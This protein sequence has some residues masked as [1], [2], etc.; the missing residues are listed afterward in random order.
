[1]HAHI[2][3]RI[4]SNSGSKREGQAGISLSRRLGCGRWF[5]TQT[6]LPN[7]AGRTASLLLSLRFKPS[8]I[9]IIW[10]APP[11]ALLLH[12]ATAHGLGGSRGEEAAEGWQK[13]GLRGSL[14]EGEEPARESR[15]LGWGRDATEKEP[16]V[17]TSPPATSKDTVR[18]TGIMAS[19]RREP[20]LG[21]WGPVAPQKSTGS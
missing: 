10:L 17:T 7:P 12:G 15:S 8:K 2:N 18:G 1:M 21:G 16:Q 13:R 4:G 6:Q 5:L 3:K 20:G 19:M 11:T 9:I 14:R